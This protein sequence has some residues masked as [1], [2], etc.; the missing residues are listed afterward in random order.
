MFMSM[1]RVTEKGIFR[2]PQSI[3][4]SLA[5]EKLNWHNRILS[6]KRGPTWFSQDNCRRIVDESLEGVRSR[7]KNN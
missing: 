5:K 1:G 3:N 7:I 2:L 4:R 6:S